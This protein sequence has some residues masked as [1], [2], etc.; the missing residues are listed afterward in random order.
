MVKQKLLEEV[1][2]IAFALFVFELE[3][4]CTKNSCTLGTP[5]GLYEGKTLVVG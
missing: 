1:L 2:G 5:Q 3:F 4:K